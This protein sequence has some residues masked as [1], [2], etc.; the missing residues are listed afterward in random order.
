MARTLDSIVNAHQ[1][2]LE[3]RN[4]DKPIWDRRLRIKHLLSRDMSDEVAQRVARASSWMKDGEERN[5]ELANIVRKFGRAKTVKALNGAL[6]HLYDL[7][8][9]DRVWIA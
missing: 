3:R 6:G 1:A 9:A 7:A 8:D 5:T 2:A 4:N